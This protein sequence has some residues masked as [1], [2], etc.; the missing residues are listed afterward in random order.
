MPTIVVH[1]ETEERY[2]VIGAGLAAYR[3]FQWSKLIPGVVGP[4]EQHEIADIAVSNAAGA[5]VWLNTNEV[6]VLT[7]DGESPASILGTACS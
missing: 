1:N 2:I 6:T 4:G 7:V 5:I 3:M